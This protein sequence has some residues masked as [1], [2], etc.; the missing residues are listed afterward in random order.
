MVEG[1]AHRFWHLP[2]MRASR[3]SFSAISLIVVLVVES[4]AALLTAVAITCAPVAGNGV[5]AGSADQEKG[6][7]SSDPQKQVKTDC[8]ARRVGECANWRR[9]GGAGGGSSP[10][11]L[12]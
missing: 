1:Q 9:V 6:T 5:S 7:L 10:A 12:V 8:T 11:E 3:P 4:A 2:T